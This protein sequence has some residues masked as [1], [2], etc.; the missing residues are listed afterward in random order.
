MSKRELQNLIYADLYSTLRNAFKGPKL[1]RGVYANC[2]I[3]YVLDSDRQ[4]LDILYRAQGVVF[5]GLYNEFNWLLLC[6]CFYYNSYSC[7]WICRGDSI[8]YW[9]SVIFSKSLIYNDF[10][11]VDRSVQFDKMDTWSR[12]DMQWTRPKIVWPTSNCASMWHMDYTRRLWRCKTV[13]GHGNPSIMCCPCW[14]ISR[15]IVTTWWTVSRI[16]DWNCRAIL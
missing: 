7:F 2:V 15:R 16:S 10:S 6:Y 8:S 14:R 3:L 9:S 11:R 4:E 12:K 1:C 13:T 5:E